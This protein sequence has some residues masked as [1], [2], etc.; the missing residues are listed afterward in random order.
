MIVSIRGGTS[1]SF[2]HQT[3]KLKVMGPA[4][5]SGLSPDKGDSCVNF[6]TQTGNQRL[7][8]SKQK[9][10]KQGNQVSYC[11]TA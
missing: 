6:C 4:Q 3:Q 2:Q 9:Q 10:E 5:A 7:A 11:L 8:N 1:K